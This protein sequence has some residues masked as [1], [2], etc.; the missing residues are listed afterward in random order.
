[1]AAYE[2][3]TPATAGDAMVRQADEARLCQGGW[4]IRDQAVNQKV[5]Y[6]RN[7]P[8]SLSVPRW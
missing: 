4:S 5:P 8:Y 2:R 1:M 3:L 6:L 7:N